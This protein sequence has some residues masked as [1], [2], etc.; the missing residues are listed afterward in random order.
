[1]RSGDAILFE[2]I[3]EPAPIGEVRELTFS[4]LCLTKHIIPRIRDIAQKD[5]DA[6][7]N[8]RDFIFLTPYVLSEEPCATAFW[9]TKS[10][11]SVRVEH[12]LR[13]PYPRHAASPDGRKG[14]RQSL[15]WAGKEKVPTKIYWD[16][17][18]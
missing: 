6:N 16:F 15:P 12:T 13:A 5:E 8:K 7:H 1:M 9:R 18:V 2:C 3:S 10:G 14:L 4:S 11:D 17:E